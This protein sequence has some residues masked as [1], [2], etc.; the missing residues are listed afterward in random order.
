MTVPESEIVK[1]AL[2]LKGLTI[3]IAEDDPTNYRL[4]VAMLK[5]SGAKIHWA[6]DGQEAITFIENKLKDERILV[7]MDIKMPVIDGF[8]ANRQIKLIDRNIPVI[9]V[10]AYAQI[11]DRE[12]I[13]SSGF[14]GYISKPFKLDTLI[15]ELSRHVTLPE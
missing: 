15:R 11:P 10:T 6:Q 14:N 12:K 8:E 3:L 5:S 7:L 2:W 4:L 13:M 1:N 9:A